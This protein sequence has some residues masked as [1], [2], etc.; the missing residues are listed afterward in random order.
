MPVL[1]P[2]TLHHQLQ[3]PISIGR[4][5][6]L[7]LLVAVVSDL[8]P[9]STAESDMIDMVPQVV[10]LITKIGSFQS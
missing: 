9:E 10:V 8:I 6:G 7:A 4:L 3:L 2:T 5:V 1:A